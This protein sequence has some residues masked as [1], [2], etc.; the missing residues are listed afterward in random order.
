MLVLVAENSWAV[1]VDIVDM[2][3]I[4]YATFYVSRIHLLFIPPCGLPAMPPDK[5]PRLL[6]SCTVFP[7]AFIFH[8]KDGKGNE[9]TVSVA[10]A[11]TTFSPLL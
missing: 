7:F 8:M 4:Q 6:S 9:N 10:R 5:S 2:W 3:Y 1:S 11:F